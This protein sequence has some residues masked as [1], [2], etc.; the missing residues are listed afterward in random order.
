MPIDYDDDDAVRG[1]G[2]AVVRVVYALALVFVKFTVSA[3]ILFACGWFWVAIGRLFLGFMQ[4]V[5]Q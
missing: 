1:D 4:G 2:S 5:F 3:A